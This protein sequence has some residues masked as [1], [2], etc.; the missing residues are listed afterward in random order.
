M[1]VC[2]GVYTAQQA[3][4]NEISTFTFT[5]MYSGMLTHSQLCLCDSR[6]AVHPFKP[7]TPLF[8]DFIVFFFKYNKKKCFLSKETSHWH[9]LRN[10]SLIWFLF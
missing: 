3:S 8:I 10:V 2:V 1:C 7:L 4:L 9:Y 6:D 5:L